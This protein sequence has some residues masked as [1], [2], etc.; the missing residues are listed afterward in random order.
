LKIEADLTIL[1]WTS[2]FNAASVLVEEISNTTSN[3]MV[4]SRTELTIYI[5]TVRNTKSSIENKRVVRD[6]ASTGTEIITFCAVS[7]YTLTAINNTG[8]IHKIIS[9]DTF[10]ADTRL[11]TTETLCLRT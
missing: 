5:I 10:L 6:T 3:T 1:D 2:I 7:N 11:A 4:R 8:T 9:I